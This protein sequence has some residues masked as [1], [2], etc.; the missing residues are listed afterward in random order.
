MTQDDP[1]IG[2]YRY[3]GQSNSSHNFPATS[4]KLYKSFRYEVEFF[5]AYFHLDFGSGS[6]QAWTDGVLQ[7]TFN[8]DF[9]G[10]LEVKNR[11]RGKQKNEIQ[12]QE[13]VG[14]VGR[15]LKDTRRLPNLNEQ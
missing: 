9:L 5:H 1:Y 8:N 10:I 13:E 4:L 6:F 15:L 7:K 14:M 3:F 2:N 12:M 11:P